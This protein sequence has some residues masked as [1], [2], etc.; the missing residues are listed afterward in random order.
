MNK[1][2]DTLRKIL[3]PLLAFI[4]MTVS[5]SDDVYI[6]RNA[7]YYFRNPFTLTS[8][9]RDFLVK[10]EV[11]SVYLHLFDV[12][13]DSQ[14]QPVTVN[15]I[16]FKDRLPEN[17]EMVPVIS[18]SSDVITD[19]L[20]LDQLSDYV[21]KNVDRILSENKYEF[22]REIQI[23]FA[24]TPENQDAYFA[25][26]RKLSKRVKA[27]DKKYQVSVTVRLHQLKAN[28]PPTDYVVLVLFD[29]DDGNVP[30]STILNYDYIHNRVEGLMTYRKRFTTTLPLYGFDLVYRDSVF[31]Y[32]ARGL[33]LTDTTLYDKV[34]DNTYMCKQ[35]QHVVLAHDPDNTAARIY[36]GDVVRHIHPSSSMLDSVASLISRVRPDDFGNIVIYQLDDKCIKSYT[37]EYFRNIFKGGSMIK[38]EPLGWD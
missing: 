11:N 23:D 31:Q 28:I 15:E 7:V 20:D 1:I 37:P 9:E 38:D 4:F 34:G 12:N 22:P 36:P 19:S 13:L 3:L 6:P 8:Q 30:R 14:K 10:Q 16:K 33:S 24:W 27:K 29:T 35:Y 25:L 26:L 2:S 18:F 17:V 21:I 32:E 5:C